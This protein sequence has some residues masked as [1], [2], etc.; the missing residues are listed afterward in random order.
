[1]KKFKKALA[2]TMACFL[3]ISIPTPAFAADE[4]LSSS[5]EAPVESITPSIAKSLDSEEFSNAAIYAINVE[6]DAEK[7]VTVPLIITQDGFL[8]FSIITDNTS[9]GTFTYTISSDAEKQDV[10]VSDSSDLTDLSEFTGLESFDKGTYYLT[11][12]VVADGSTD[13]Y[14][15]FGFNALLCTKAPKTLKNNQVVASAKAGTSDY[16]KF[17][18]TKSARIGFQGT[19]LSNASTLKFTICDSKKKAL[20]KQ[21]TMGNTAFQYFALAKGTYYLKVNTDSSIYWM[22]YSA[23]AAT[24]KGG[25]SSSKPTNLKVNTK[26]SGLVTASDKKNKT[27]YFKITTTAAGQLKG[28]YIS[29]YGQGSIKIKIKSPGMKEKSATVKSGMYREYTVTETLDQ[30]GQTYYRD[31]KFPK[32]TYTIQIIKP[33]STSSG[34]YEIGTKLYK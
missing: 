15:T 18:L 31:G 16:H 14:F 3:A 4:I 27:D 29:Y 10:I 19:T 12:D 21:T 26:T 23:T 32:G 6:N 34:S 24:D 11:I 5:S 17:T 8:S 2:I 22:A 25:V 9:A 30:Y 33:D 20:T 7:T 28:F 13:P 1:M